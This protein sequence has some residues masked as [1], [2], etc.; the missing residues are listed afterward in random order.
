VCDPT[1]VKIQNSHAKLS[2]F[3]PGV[4]YVSEE[5]IIPSVF[6]RNLVTFAIKTHKRERWCAGIGDIFEE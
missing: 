2:D 3:S 6:E 5:V 1:S 4:A